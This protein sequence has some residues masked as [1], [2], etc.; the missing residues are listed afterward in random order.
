VLSL[1]AIPINRTYLCIRIWLRNIE[2]GK[3]PIEY[4]C[5]SAGACLSRKQWDV[6]GVACSPDGSVV[7]LAGDDGK[8]RLLN[9]ETG[10]ALRTLTA[11][12]GAAYS[13]AISPDGRMLASA[14]FEGTIRVWDL[15][16]GRELRA[17]TGHKGW[18][19]A[20]AFAAGGRELVSAGRDS[21]VRLWDVA[22]GSSLRVIDDYQS[23]VFAVAASADGRWL[24]SDKGDSFSV[25]EIRTGKQIADGAPGQWGINTLVFGPRAHELMTSGYDGKLWR[26]DITAS[27]V[28]G[29]VP[30][31]GGP[32]ISIAVSGDGLLLAALCSGDRT[33]KIFD[34]A[35]WKMISRLDGTSYPV[36]TAAF[37]A[38]GKWLAAGG[39]DSPVRVWRR[40]D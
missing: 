13:V 33:V 25:R 29:T 14:G 9:S 27:A 18:V 39:G 12:R 31:D 5:L 11:H 7:A 22:S 19:N 8:V 24:A 28:A 40:R 37:S 10:A 16:S 30:I 1:N 38:D 32:I 21:T 20:I 15:A 2:F 6:N 17:F 23:E 26:W 35:S 34:T 4:G 36:G 3:A